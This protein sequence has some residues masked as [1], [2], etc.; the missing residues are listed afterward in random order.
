MSTQPSSNKTVYGES[1]EEDELRRF[2]FI[3]SCLSDPDAVAYADA[4]RAS[5][6]SVYDALMSYQKGV[7]IEYVIALHRA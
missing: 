6:I 5:G 7:S 1:P 2:K 3:L 4:C